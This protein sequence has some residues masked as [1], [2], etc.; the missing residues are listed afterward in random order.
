MSS[1][2]VFIFL[3]IFLMEPKKAMTNSM[4]F[5]NAMTFPKALL[6]TAVFLGQDSD[7]LHNG[8]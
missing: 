7:G 6:F 5:I 8:H 4:G 1:N 3:R 2:L